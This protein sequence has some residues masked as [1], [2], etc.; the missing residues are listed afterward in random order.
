LAQPETAGPAPSP[1]EEA[2]L[3]ALARYEDAYRKEGYQWVAG[4]DE[5]GRGPLAGPVVACAVILPAG[6]RLPGVNDSKKL[7]PLKRERLYRQVYREAL[8]VAVAF[9]DAAAVDALNILRAT[10]A[11]MGNALAAL[12]PQPDIAL[13]DGLPVPGLSLPHQAIVGGDGLCA[14]IAAASVVAK[15]TRDALMAE[16]HR[17]FPQYG[18][19]AHK[20][21]PTARHRA[22][23]ARYGPCC[24]HRKSFLR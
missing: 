10:H 24:I 11:A 22:A 7:S 3:A 20:G 4:V 8:A 6:C 18:F 23:L 14:A 13:V 2:R 9:R 12:R 5:A 19:D 16:Y 17:Q 21:Y 15:V 1:G